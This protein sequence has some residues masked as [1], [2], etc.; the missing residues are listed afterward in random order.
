MDLRLPKAF[1]GYYFKGAEISVSAIN[2]KGLIIN[3][4]L[5]AVSNI[6]PRNK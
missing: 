5:N 4:K 6:I 2:G 3:R 1:T